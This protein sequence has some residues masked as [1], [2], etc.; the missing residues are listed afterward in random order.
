M[1]AI[2]R[3]ARA[4]T[5]VTYFVLA[6]AFSWAF[7]VPMAVL[8]VRVY[9][10]Q[11]WPTHWPGLFGPLVA[12]L[13]TTAAVAG[14][15]RIRDLLARMVRWRVHPVWYAAA[16]SPLAFFAAAALALGLT[17]QGWPDLGELGRFSGLPAVAA[18]LMWFL[19]LG[20]GLGEEAGWRGFAVPELRRRHSLLVTA[21]VVGV[22][23][24]AWHAPALLVVENYR[25]LGL[26]VLPMFGLGI[27][28]G[29]IFLAW[30]YE[31]SGGSILLV[32]LWHATY[33]LVSGTAAAHGL[34]AAIV[35]S[36][37]MAWAVLIVLDELWRWRKNR[38]PGTAARRPTAA[39]A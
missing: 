18:G 30:L 16:F 15:A 19:L 34:V 26:A 39:G 3:F 7:W 4:H 35:S 38:Q 31:R 32:T 1:T 33:N 12:A 29:S 21:L 37:V 2:L 23:W 6:Y 24:A 36:G 17:G 25:Q 28:A 9:Q 13:V 8:G 14:R 22:L 10:G 20:N 5:L 27:I 11:G